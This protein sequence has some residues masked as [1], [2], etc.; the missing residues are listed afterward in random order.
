[1]KTLKSKEVQRPARGH[2]GLMIWEGNEGLEGIGHCISAHSILYSQ[3]LLYSQ[4]LVLAS[5]SPLLPLQSEG[6][7][8]RGKRE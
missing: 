4:I 1:M 3:T 5:M 8:M 7:K 6:R 2:I